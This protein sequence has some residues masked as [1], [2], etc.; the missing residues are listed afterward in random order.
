MP[1]HKAFLLF[2]IFLQKALH[3][4]VEIWEVLLT[5]HQDP[6]FFGE[7]AVVTISFEYEEVAFLHRV[8]DTEGD[9]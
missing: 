3:L 1:Y 7:E 5:Y 8:M 2:G 4:G 6:P 9:A